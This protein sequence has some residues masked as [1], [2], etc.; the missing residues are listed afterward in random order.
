MAKKFY[1]Y[2]QL[3]LSILGSSWSNAQSQ[4]DQNM[5]IQIRDRLSPHYDNIRPQIIYRNEGVPAS[6]G[7]GYIY[8]DPDLFDILRGF[9]STEEVEPALAF[10]IS[11]ELSHHHY[12]QAHL[13]EF[14]TLNPEL[15]RK[16]E[17]QADQSGFYVASLAHYPLN[18]E[19]I[20]RL[21]EGLY[22][23]YHN[24]NLDGYPDLD[25]RLKAAYESIDAI[26]ENHLPSVFQT[27][28]FLFS[29]GQYPEAAVC[30]KY[31]QSHY[32]RE[33]I[34]NDLAVIYLAGFLE[35]D[36]N[37][38]K[39]GVFK[40][41][42]SFDFENFRGSLNTSPLAPPFDNPQALRSEIKY[43]LH[44]ALA[45]NE[46]YEDSYTN[47]AIYHHIEGSL[48]LAQNQIVNITERG[49][50]FS[51]STK[52]MQAILYA[53]AD[54]TDLARAA[55]GEVASL[56]YLNA[57]YNVLVMEAILS[58]GVGKFTEI[59][60]KLDDN[61]LLSIKE[62]AR[63]RVYRP[64]S[65]YKSLSPDPEFRAIKSQN[66]SWPSL[67]L[68]PE[69]KQ[70]S[71]IP[72]VTIDFALKDE[73]NADFQTIC[74]SYKSEAFG[75]YVTLNIIFIKSSF[76][77]VSGLGVRIGDSSEVLFQKYGRPDKGNAPI[78]E[79]DA[80]YRYNDAQIMF[81]VKNGRVVSW[82]WFWEGDDE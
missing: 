4:A 48:G 66:I 74:L 45:K 26:Y 79:I 27:A 2:Y 23:R 44:Q 20:K 14:S 59:L 28:S 72:P 25:G 13:R 55:F 31:I 75:A 1:L 15:L 62:E 78:V 16:I 12:H 19:L 42:L 34:S 7:L 17:Y 22:T 70:I 80:F 58:K 38:A 33:S 18:P 64:K 69:P 30:L 57:Q 5:V 82:A 73:P 35:M 54:Q 37:Y 32:N 43:Q 63:N 51:P 68:P 67:D 56:G 52:I 40:Y 76:N 39:R 81:E 9:L 6:S 49:L 60:A 8:L 10:I 41:P 36:K 21:I 50:S 71:Y 61:E 53:Y 77:G 47:L 11:H 46:N 24:L 65:Q 29:E 3:V